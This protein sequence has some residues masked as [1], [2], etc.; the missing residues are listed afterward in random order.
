MTPAAATP[1]RAL[2]GDRLSVLRPAHGS[3]QAIASGDL[4]VLIRTNPANVTVI[5]KVPGLKATQPSGPGHKLG[6]TVREPVA[7]DPGKPPNPGSSSSTQTAAMVA[8]RR[9]ARSRH[10]ICRTLP[11]GASPSSKAHPSLRLSKTNAFRPAVSRAPHGASR[12]FL[13]NSSVYGILPDADRVAIRPGS[14]VTA[15]ARYALLIEDEALI[16]AVA[17]ADAS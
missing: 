7:G 17:S 15:A 16:A 13:T 12:Y 6:S 4:R 8:I 10:Q 1:D 11:D 3:R 5:T 2:K 9:S 14:S